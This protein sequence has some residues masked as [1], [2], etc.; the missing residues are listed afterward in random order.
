[1][2]FGNSI[3][4]EPVLRGRRGWRR[5]GQTAIEYLLVTASLFFVFVTMYRALQY[6]VANQFKRGGQVILKVY[7]EDP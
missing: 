6:A 1:M 7:I 3:K 5:R 4:A 2:S